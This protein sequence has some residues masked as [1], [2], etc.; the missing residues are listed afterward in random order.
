MLKLIIN[1]PTMSSL[2]DLDQQAGGDV[3]EESHAFDEDAEGLAPV[4]CSS[5]PASLSPASFIVCSS[6]LLHGLKSPLQNGY[7]PHTM[8]QALLLQSAGTC[9]STDAM[10]EVQRK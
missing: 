2:H 6:S 3:L 9:C 5:L 4:S 10:L 8:L 1:W 7:Y